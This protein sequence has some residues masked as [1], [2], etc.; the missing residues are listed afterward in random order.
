M[1]RGEVSMVDLR[2]AKGEAV[3]KHFWGG[4]ERGGW[5]TST[6]TSPSKSLSGLAMRE[7]SGP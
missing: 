1:N 3:T 4:V 7:P 6:K 2:E 5:L